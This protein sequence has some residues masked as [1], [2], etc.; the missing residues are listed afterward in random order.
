MRIAKRADII[1]AFWDDTSGGTKHCMDM[2]KIWAKKYTS[3]ILKTDKLI[4]YGAYTALDVI[5]KEL[6]QNQAFFTAYEKYEFLL[7][8]S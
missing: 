6:S 5:K 8:I 3:M 7:C 1:I 2:L 4:L